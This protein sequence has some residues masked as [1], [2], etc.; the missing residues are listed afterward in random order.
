MD[1]HQSEPSHMLRVWTSKEPSPLTLSA[2]HVVFTSNNTKYAG[3]LQPGDCLMYWN[4]T[5]MEEM[6]VEAI[7][8][9]ISYGFWSPLTRAGHLLVDGFLTSCYASYPHQVFPQYLL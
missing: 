4:G 5:A 3:D 8:P 1:R 2:S 9:T 6:E 7:L